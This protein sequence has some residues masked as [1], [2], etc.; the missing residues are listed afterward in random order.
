VILVRRRRLATLLF[1]AVLLFGAAAPSGAVPQ[2]IGKPAI[3]FKHDEESTA[4]LAGR[5]LAVLALAALAAYGGALALKRLGLGRPGLPGK[6]R[7]VRL[8]E[9][10][11]L[12]RRSVLHV[13]HY[14]GAEL[15]L[16][17]GEHGVHLVSSRPEGAADA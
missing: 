11:R 13:V 15:L 8:L 17:E 1:G 2:P 16:A 10:V 3:P 5:G 4:A 6:A 12:S 7:R 14:R 9:T